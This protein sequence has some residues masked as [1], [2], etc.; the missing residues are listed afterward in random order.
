M[1]FRKSRFPTFSSCPDGHHQP[2]VYTDLDGTLLDFESYALDCTLPAVKALQQA[3]I[4]VVFCSSKTFAEQLYYRRAFG[5]K[6][7]FIVENG[8]AIVIPV[9]YFTFRYVFQTTRHGFHLIELGVSARH[10]ISHLHTLRSD[11][12]INFRCFTELSIDELSGITGLPPAMA[13]RAQQRDYSET[14]IPQRPSEDLSRLETALKQKGLKLHHGGRFFTV[15][16]READKGR[17]VKALNRLLEQKFGP[18]LTIGIGDSAND[19]PMLK[20]V[21]YPFLVQQPGGRWADLPVPATKIPAIGPHGFVDL[22]EWLLAE[23]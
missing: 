7:P 10:I 8:S 14:I 23:R 19:A 21:D 22:A 6:D 18:I 15:I 1:K 9:D 5:L 13:Q 20:A 11:L 3:G 12:G 4:P 16:S 17:A 2:V